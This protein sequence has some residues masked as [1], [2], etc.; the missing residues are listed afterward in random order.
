MEV[1]YTQELLTR[2][3]QYEEGLISKLELI[4]LVNLWVARRLHVF[5]ADL[6]AAEDI[7]GK[8]FN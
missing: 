1:E 3:K 2:I 7:D 5:T 4:N 8:H 6:I